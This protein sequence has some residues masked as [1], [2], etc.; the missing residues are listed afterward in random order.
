MVATQEPEA[1]ASCHDAGSWLVRRRHRP[2][3]LT[4]RAKMKASRS[5]HIYASPLRLVEFAPRSDWPQCRRPTATGLPTESSS[6]VVRI[7]ASE[8]AEGLASRI[9]T[10]EEEVLSKLSTTLLPSLPSWPSTERASHIGQ[11]GTVLNII[12]NLAHK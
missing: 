8:S 10:T 1:A 11:L 3:T 6:A 12:A 5:H 7:E 2:R 4:W 9:G